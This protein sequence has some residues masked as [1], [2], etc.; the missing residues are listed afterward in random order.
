MFNEE[1]LEQLLAQD[2]CQMLEE[3]ANIIQVDTSTISK[4]LKLLEMVENQVNYVPQELMP[5]DFERCFFIF[6]L[7]KGQKRKGFPH[8]IVIG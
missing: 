2:L 5:R 7:L 4:H 8:R 6:E 3:I 1:E